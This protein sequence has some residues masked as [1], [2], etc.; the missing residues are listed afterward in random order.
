MTVTGNKS[1]PEAEKEG[2]SRAERMFFYLSAGIFEA[3]LNKNTALHRSWLIPLQENKVEPGTSS[4]A[5]RG[6]Y[7]NT[8]P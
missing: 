1:A 7:S 5:G 4:M 6:N 8:P 3:S 2:E